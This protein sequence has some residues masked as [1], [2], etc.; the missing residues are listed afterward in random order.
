MTD[1]PLVIVGAGC[2]G[3]SLAVALLDAGW[4]PPLVLLERRTDY[5]RDRTW[6]FWDT[7]DVPWTHLAD[8]SWAR[9]RIGDAVQEADEHPYV[10][11]PADRFYAAALG[12]LRRARHVELRR[13]VRVLGLAE[14]GDGVQLRTTAGV[15]SAAHV[16]DCRGPAHPAVRAAVRD[17]LT[18]RFLGQFVRTDRPCFDP[19]EATLMAFHGDHPREL[20]FVYTLPV[21]DR[22]ALVEDTSFAWHTT[23][24]RDR[25]RA[26][27]AAVAQPFTVTGSEAGAIPMSAVSVPQTSRVWAAGLPAGAARPSSGYAFVRIQAQAAA[28][29]QALCDGRTRPPRVGSARRDALDAVFLRAL[30]A[31]PPAFAAHLEA[32]ASGVDGDVLARFMNDASSPADELRVMAALPPLPFLRAAAGTALP[33][34]ARGNG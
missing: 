29:A 11:L 32:L 9:W 6:C 17:G 8:A 3:L 18:Q 10:Q 21:S 28:M 7:G 19:G 14:R 24:S 33:L 27:A 34:P 25:R 5:T 4:D 30:D 31:D 26:I 22:E 12:R 16:V 2:A 23:P 1:R 15:V 20:R 13:G